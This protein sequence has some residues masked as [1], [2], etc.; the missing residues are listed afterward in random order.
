[1]SSDTLQRKQDDEEAIR[2]WHQEVEDSTNRS[3]S[4]AYLSLWVDDM[5][6]MPPNAPII[7]GKDN[8]RPMVEEFHTH[9]KVEQKVT[10]DEIE[11]GDN[12]AF[13][14]IFSREKFTPKADA[15]PLESWDLKN[16]FAFRRQPDGSWKGTHCIWNSNKQ[17]T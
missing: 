5:I 6:W 9:Y 12:I 8:C 17:A 16:I 15:P 10:I 3:D 7:I 13:S 2:K 11:I 14:R 4:E 1:V